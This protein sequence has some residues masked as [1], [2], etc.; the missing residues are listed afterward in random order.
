MLY[1]PLA[2]PITLILRRLNSNATVPLGKVFLTPATQVDVILGERL[3][4]TLGILGFILVPEILAV[5]V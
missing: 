2:T 5:G 3:G 1:V 4:R